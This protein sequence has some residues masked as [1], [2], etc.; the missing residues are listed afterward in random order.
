M[1][2]STVP[3]Y[4]GNR[5]PRENIT[6]YGWLYIP[7]TP[8]FREIQEM[9]LARGIE[10]SYEAI[11]FWRLTFGAGYAKGRRRRGFGGGTGHQDEVFSKINDQFVNLRR[12]VD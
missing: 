12:A 4:R 11:R 2:T 3:S 5:F 8:S 6:H 7:F 9:M 1:D 10:I